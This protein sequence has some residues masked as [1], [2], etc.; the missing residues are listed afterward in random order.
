MNVTQHSLLQMDG[1]KEVTGQE[2]PDLQVSDCRLLD[3]Q[4]LLTGHTSLNDLWY[5]SGSCMLALI[6]VDRVFAC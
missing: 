4:A 1:C 3:C 6:D 5:K 2:I